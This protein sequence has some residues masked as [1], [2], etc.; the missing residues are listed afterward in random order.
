MV[1]GQARGTSPALLNLTP[2]DHE[3]VVELSGRKVRQ[4]VHI[5]AGITAQVVVP[6][7]KK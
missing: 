7:P 1:D 6:I 5:E 4:M 2:G 3:L